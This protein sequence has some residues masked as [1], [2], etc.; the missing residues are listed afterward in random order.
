MYQFK[1]ID[2]KTLFPCQFFYEPAAK[3]LIEDLFSWV[4][5]LMHLVCSLYAQNNEEVAH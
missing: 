2:N 5:L 4:Q 3:N 1:P